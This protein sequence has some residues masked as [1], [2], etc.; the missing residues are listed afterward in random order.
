MST[1]ITLLFLLVLVL[2]AST[3]L[4][5]GPLNLPGLPE[6]EERVAAGTGPQ[7]PVGEVYGFINADVIFDSG[8]NDP[9]WFDAMRPSKLPSFEGEFGKGGNTH[10]SVRQ[11]RFGVKSWVPTEMGQLKGIL[12]GDLFG[13]G[14]DAGQTTLRLRHAYFEIGK[15]G[16]GQYHSPFMDASVFP[17]SQNYWGPSGMDIYRNVQVRYMPVMS[18]RHHVSVALEKPGAS[19]DGGI[20]DEIL[21]ARGLTPRFPVPDLSAEYRHTRD[22]G[23]VEIAGVLRR[24]QWDDL[25]KNEFDLSGGGTGWGFNLSSNLSVGSTGS[26]IKG[27]VLY[28]EGIE[29]Y[30]FDAIA[31]VAVVED[32]IDPVSPLKG[33]LLPVFAF[34]GF[35]PGFPICLP[36]MAPLYTREPP[37][38]RNS[39]RRTIVQLQRPSPQPT[40]TWNRP[41]PLLSGHFS[42]TAPHLCPFFA[43]LRCTRPRVS[44]PAPAAPRSSAAS[45]RRAAGSDDLPP[46]GA[47]SIWRASPAGLRFSPAAAG[48]SS[49]TSA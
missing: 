36:Q 15:F 7:G 11:T 35:Y 28:G 6:L 31:D 39:V 49:A 5:Q 21:R 30:V 29:N 17:R 45:R 27:S 12:E 20:H 37:S 43:S 2:G 18:D 33:E 16:A 1:R 32:F 44:L 13:V 47:S 4:G 9:D 22:R 34:L 14:P 41:E 3:A 38:A 46:A 25:T 19:G 8:A 24:I 26:V 23:Y 48:D 42:D 10:F 40:L